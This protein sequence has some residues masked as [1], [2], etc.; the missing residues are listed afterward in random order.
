[1]K[2]AHTMWVPLQLHNIHCPGGHH[3]YPA[4]AQDRLRLVSPKHE[5]PARSSTMNQVPT[6]ASPPARES[7]NRSAHVVYTVWYQ[8]SLGSSASSDANS[9]PQGYR[10]RSMRILATCTC[11]LVSPMTSVGAA[12]SLLGPTPYVSFSDSPFSAVA[13]AD[14]FH[15]EDFE[16]NA[17]DVP[18]VSSTSATGSP[19]S[20]FVLV[21]GPNTDSVDSDDGIVDGSGTAGHS[22]VHSRNMGGVKFVFG[23]ATLGTLPT[24]AGFVW[25]DGYQFS[26]TV[27]FE[28]FDVVGASLGTLTTNLGD[29]SFAGGT[30]EDRFFGIIHDGGVSAIQVRTTSP[31][32]SNAIE[33]DHLQYGSVHGIVPEP[34]S[35]LLASSATRA[36]TATSERTIELPLV[37]E[38]GERHAVS[39]P[40][41]AHVLSGRRP[42]L[43]QVGAPASTCDLMRRAATTSRA[44]RAS[45]VVRISCR[46]TMYGRDGARPEQNGHAGTSVGESLL[47]PCRHP[48]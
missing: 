21:P 17:F 39:V 13:F 14:Y 19:F 44:A 28:A 41:V 16:D 34:S 22:Y 5:S 4:I 25:T 9:N 1:M 15:F 23:G 3:E 10:F 24:H 48:W 7:P 20:S 32:S 46:A 37:A 43:L 45:V 27:E 35:A 40:Q 36:C 42:A 11:I 8:R 30:A 31:N 12:T 18:G 38:S 26:Q 6:A 29:G 33:V 2:P 47:Q